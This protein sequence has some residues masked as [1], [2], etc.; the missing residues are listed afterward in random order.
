MNDLERKKAER[1][2]IEHTT[3]YS[4]ES[5]KFQWTE[6]KVHLIGNLSIRQNANFPFL[7]SV[8]GSIYFYDG[9]TL[10]A[11]LLKKISGSVNFSS[12][13]KIDIPSLGHIGGSLYNYTILKLPSLESVNGEFN[14][15]ANIDVPSLTSIGGNIKVNYS[16]NSKIK[17]PKLKTVGGGIFLFHKSILIAKELKNVQGNIKVFN[18]AELYTPKLKNIGGYVRVWEHGELYT[19]N[20]RNVGKD[21]Y[22][23]RYSKITIPTLINEDFIDNMKDGEELNGFIKADGLVIQFISKKEKGNI[24]IYTTP[25]V[26]PKYV[27]KKGEY[28]SH[29]DNIKQGILDIKIKEVGQDT[30]YFD[31]L[32]LNSVLTH[33]DA[34]VMYRVVTNACEKGTELFINNN[35]DKVKK[36]YT[37]KEIIKLTSGAYYSDK[38]VDF[39]E[40]KVATKR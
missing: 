5:V 36:E 20:L 21:S 39:F 10:K 24:L 40:K 26:S 22:F 13:A 12:K 27:I 31:N 25:F 7:E 19:P 17:S 15:Y 4:A 8:R 11:P 29:C 38:L 1:D 37:V 35:Q 2:I 18:K 16:S 6:N 23:G 3:Y 34:I 28:W 9:G 30:S 32:T 33:E 14:V